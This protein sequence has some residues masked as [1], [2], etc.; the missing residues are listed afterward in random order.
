VIKS[1][2]KAKKRSLEWEKSRSPKTR[3]TARHNRD[4]MLQKL[5]SP[6]GEAKGLDTIGKR[7]QLKLPQKEVPNA[8]MQAPP[9]QMHFSLF[10]FPW[11]ETPPG[12]MIWVLSS[13]LLVMHESSHKCKHVLLK[14]IKSTTTC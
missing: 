7:A 10:F 12:T 8:W 6:Q 13:P 11:C 1:Q 4:K 2:T 5:S 14:Y 9:E 3:A